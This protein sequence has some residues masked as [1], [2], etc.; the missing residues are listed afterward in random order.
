MLL[1][2]RQ[3]FERRGGGGWQNPYVTDG[4]VAMWDGEWNAGGGVHDAAA[5]TWVDIVSGFTLSRKGSPVIADKGVEFDGASCFGGSAA[6]GGVKTV[7]CVLSLGT[8]V[9][10]A[11][12]EMIRLDGTN[13]Y[14][15]YVN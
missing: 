1:G 3:F 11:D 12:P 10:S 6:I 15:Y 4:L 2:A 9:G 8:Q 5:T 7:E 14:K 13:Q